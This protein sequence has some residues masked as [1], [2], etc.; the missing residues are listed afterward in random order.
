M[1]CNAKALSVYSIIIIMWLKLPIRIDLYLVLV[2]SKY[3]AY[4]T[5]NQIRPDLF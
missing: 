4:I 2:A 1:I 3:N 5:F